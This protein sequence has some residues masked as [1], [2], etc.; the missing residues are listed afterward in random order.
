MWIPLRPI[1]SCIGAPTYELSMYLASI[2]KHLVNDTEYSVKNAKQL[3]EFISSQEGAEDELVV[4]FDM[5]SLFTSIPVNMA[6]DIVQSKLRRSDDRKN[7]TQLTRSWAYS[8]FCC[9]T[10]ILYLKEPSSTRYQDV[11]WNLQLV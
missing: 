10:A 5:V 11:P 4:S 7:H 6:I 1:N 9:T 2:L 8:P 3:A